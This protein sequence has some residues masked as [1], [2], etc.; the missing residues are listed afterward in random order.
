MRHSMAKSE[1]VSGKHKVSEDDGESSK[2]EQAQK[3][4]D[5]SPDYRSLLDGERMP[6]LRQSGP[7]RCFFEGSQPFVGVSLLFFGK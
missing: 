5:V 3:A 1:I 6:D 2:D 7:N 4:K